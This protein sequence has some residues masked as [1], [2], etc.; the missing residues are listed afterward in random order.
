MK[1]TVK[2]YYHGTIQKLCES[3]IMLAL[4]MVLSL[5]V[6]Y[7][8]PQ[9]GS[10]TLCST[11]PIIVIGYRYGLKW[12]VF[13]GFAYGLLQL[14]IFGASD[15]KA[16]SVVTLIGSVFLDYLL[17]FGSVGLSALFRKLPFGLT[18]GAAAGNIFRGIF[19]FVSGV[20]LWS[21]IVKD[22]WWPSIVY[23]FT[24]NF[25]GYLLWDI[26]ITAAGALLLEITIKPLLVSHK[27][28]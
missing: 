26:L 14:I 8:M 6:I 25:F 27:A 12:G 28:I 16:V 4:A 9:G 7:H 20:L 21:N 3:G 11:L 15:L 13:T 10:V 2:T 23:S 24:Y 18:I 17:C 1:N 22:G 19:N 5:I